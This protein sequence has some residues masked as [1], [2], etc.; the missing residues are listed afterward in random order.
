MK[1]QRIAEVALEKIAH[2]DQQLYGRRL[3]EAIAAEEGLTDVFGGAFAEDGQTGV[4]GYRARQSEGDEQYPDQ[5]RYGKRQP[6]NDELEHQMISPAAND[7]SI[8]ET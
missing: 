2:V 1:A 7:P 6:S 8:A 3:I 4:A 5:Y